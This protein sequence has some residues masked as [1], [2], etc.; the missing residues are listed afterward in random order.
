MRAR[1]IF[2][3]NGEPVYSLKDS[4]I[5]YNCK[6]LSSAKYPTTWFKGERFYELSC[7]LS[8]ACFSLL[9]PLIQKEKKIS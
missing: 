9:E 3:K 5:F 1:L 2:A 7:I 6:Y 8:E 4:V